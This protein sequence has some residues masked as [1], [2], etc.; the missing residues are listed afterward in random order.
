MQDVLTTHEPTQEARPNLVL[1]HDTI[2]GVCEGIGEEFGFNPNFL[3]VPFAAGVLWN[4]L[5]ILGMYLALGAALLVSRWI[6]PKSSPALR[7]VADR[8]SVEA[9]NETNPERL[10]A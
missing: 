4:P 8:P 3:R 2:L 5:A 6:Y 1:R 9:D 10:A 7:P